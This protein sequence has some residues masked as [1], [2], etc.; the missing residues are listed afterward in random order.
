MSNAVA[1]E[2][3]RRATVATAEG[4]KTRLTLEGE[5]KAD[6]EKKMLEARAKGH[7]AYLKAEAMGLAALAKVAKT[8]EGKF[9]QAMKVLEEG[10]AKGNTTFFDSQMIL[11]AAQTVE[12]II[13]K[14]KGGGA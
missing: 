12:T 13:A 8:D 11:N 1:A 9:M 7:A 3:N 4:E 6:A 14:A 10:F 2:F 5:G